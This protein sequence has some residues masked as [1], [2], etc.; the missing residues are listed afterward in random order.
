[1]YYAEVSRQTGPG[2][3]LAAEHEQ[4]T[5]VPFTKEELIAEPW[6]DAKT[7][8]AVQWVRL[9]KLAK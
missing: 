6:Q 3:G 1:V 7:L 2:G 8:V 9:N 4:L 5:T